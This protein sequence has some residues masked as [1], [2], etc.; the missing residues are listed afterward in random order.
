[1]FDK[2]LSTSLVPNIPGFWIAQDSE[3]VSGSERVRIWM[4]NSWICLNMPG[5]VFICLNMSEYAWICLNLPEWLLFYNSPFPHMFYNPS[6]T[7]ARGY[8]FEHLQEAR[9]RTIWLVW[10]NMRL[11][12]WGDKIWFFSITAGSISFASC[13]RINIFPSK[14]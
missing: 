11:F 14:I 6:S 5:Y 2:V 3:Y 12:S 7:W 4:N 1:M 13:F 10:R 9:A 8:L